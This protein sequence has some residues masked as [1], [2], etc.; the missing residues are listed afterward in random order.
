M[1]KH[2]IRLLGSSQKARFVAVGIVNTVTDFAVLF[3]LAVLAGLPPLAANIL[4]TTAALAVSYVLNKRAVFKSADTNNARQVLLFVVVT[5]IGLWLVQGIVII[6]VTGA[7]ESLLHAEQAVAL[8]IAKAIATIFSLTWNYVWY[9]RVVF[10]A[11]DT[12]RK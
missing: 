8:I 6:A 4:S 10:A 2:T 5:L 12:Q 1:K 3:V 11:R 9:S 7:V